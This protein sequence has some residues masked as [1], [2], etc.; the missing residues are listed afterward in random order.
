M[1]RRT[2]MPKKST[3]FA[4][5]RARR[6]AF[7]FA[8]AV[9]FLLASSAL[10]LEVTEESAWQGNSEET[11][12]QQSPS[13]HT[14]GKFH[15]A[16]TVSHA[17]ATPA[18]EPAGELV[19]AVVANELTD[20]EQFRNWMFLIEKREGK[21]TLTEVQA[22]TKT[23]PLYRLLAID[24][25][26][27]NPDQ[28]RQ[29]DARIRNLLKDPKPLQKL[30]ESQKDDE[31]KL[32]KLVSL[33]PQAF[34]YDYDG[35]EEDLLRIKFR[36]NPAYSPSSY[37]ARIVHSLAGTILVDPAQKRLAKVVAHLTGRV[38]FGY[39]LLGRVDSGTVELRRIEVTP[40]LWKTSFI[41][42]QFAGRIALFKSFTKDQ[43]E[44]RSDFQ[45]VSSDLSL[46]EAKD[47][48]VSRLP[49]S[50]RIP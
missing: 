18:V 12:S 6:L 39:G 33:M 26:A 22:D 11:Q 30:K 2:T 28:R 40:Q 47:L 45:V 25:R 1:P 23:G 27:L 19:R 37:E 24:G 29:D 4:S 16:S 43:Y 10:P 21:Q 17:F 42:I 20:R 8:A 49:P 9:S 41:N 15:P 44:Q 50:P 46:S 7:A 3:N 32:Q 36:P 14:I 38:D 35:F 5:K 48:L 13:T 34:V 31:L